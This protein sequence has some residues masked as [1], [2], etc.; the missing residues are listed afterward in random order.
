MSKGGV[1]LSFHGGVKG[2]TGS[3][4][5]LHTPA[6]KV[7]I[8]CGLHQG[9]QFCSKENYKEFGFDPS[10]VDL[11][12][13]THA[14]L[15]HC[16]R[17]PLLVKRG[18]KGDI[19]STN[20]T[21]SLANLVMEDGMRVMHYES[22]KCQLEHLYE[23][24]DLKETQARMKG[25][26]YHTEFEPLQG[27]RIHFSDAGHILG[28]SFITIV[29]DKELIGKEQDYR[30][31]FSGDIGN[32]DIPILPDTEPILKANVVICESTYGDRDHVATSERGKELVAM[33]SKV[34]GRK[35]TLL[36][37]AF[38]IERTQELI[39]EIDR[40]FD[41][42]LIP[43]VPIY[44]DSPLAI[45]AN[46]RYRHFKQ[47]LRFDR[48]ILSS[49]DQDF[50]AFPGLKETL[51]KESSMAINKDNR[52]KIII[53]GSGMMSGGRIMHH[54]KRYLPDEKAGV[55]LIGYQAEGTTGRKLQ[56]G[57]KEVTIHDEQI[58]VHAEVNKIGA[59][60][61]HGDRGKLRRWLK[62]QEGDIE[63]VFL[64]HGEIGAKN[65]FKEFLSETVHADIQIPDLGESVQLI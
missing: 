54:A 21:K 19:Y 48:A 62:P 32:D 38:S 52:P 2:V 36:I 13:L 61:A 30:I 50:F 8:D 56:D 45:R 42:G 25:V 29:I 15:D 31:V 63:K 22:Q 14:H 43:H 20:P 57:A 17:L 18:Y 49:P 24:A 23:V 64:V 37:P 6:G 1:Q 46:E 39:Y 40:L 51:P 47:Y 33:I 34:I 53:A 60:S 12:L 3:S 59:F 10:A 4:Y 7:L 44:L 11:V 9:E 28:S 5:L 26:G 55:L 65:V 27:V 58:E 35:G 16:G 41:Q